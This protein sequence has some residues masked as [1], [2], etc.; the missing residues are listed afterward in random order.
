MGQVT[1]PR[2]QSAELLT[3]EQGAVPLREEPCPGPLHQQAT[4][5]PD[6]S[7]LFFSPQPSA[8]T[9]RFAG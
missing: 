8:Q 5:S 2:K 9:G 4:G 7:F 1:A 3:L 6:P